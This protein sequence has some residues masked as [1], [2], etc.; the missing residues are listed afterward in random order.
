MSAASLVALVGSL[1]DAVREAPQLV[2]AIEDVFSSLRNHEDP[3]PAL[4]HL[5]AAAAAKELGIEWP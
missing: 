5:E 2:S 3:T 4:K 1:V